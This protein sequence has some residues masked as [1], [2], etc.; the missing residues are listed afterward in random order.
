MN[1]A[2]VRAGSF[3]SSGPSVLPT[4]PPPQVQHR[5]LPQVLNSCMGT[6]RGKALGLCSAAGMG[7]RPQRCLHACATTHTRHGAGG[8]HRLPHGCPGHLHTQGFYPAVVCTSRQQAP[9]LWPLTPHPLSHN[10]KPFNPYPA[11]PITDS[12]EQA[13]IK[14]PPP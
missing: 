5:V 10:W 9:S 1:T 7:M 12:V 4:I 13:A 2:F 8:V 6:Q 11:Q 14:T 3:Q